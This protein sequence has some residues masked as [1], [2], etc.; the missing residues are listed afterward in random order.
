MILDY[1]DFNKYIEN[2][3]EKKNTS[4]S[5]I[6][7][8]IYET[9]A[10]SDDLLKFSFTILDLA[11]KHRLV[12]PLWRQ[13]HQILLQ[14]D[15]KP[16]IHRFR[17]I[18]ILEVDIQ[19]VMKRWW[20]RE[21]QDSVDSE[22]LMNQKQYARKGVTTMAKLW[23]RH[24]TFSYNMSMGQPFVQ[25]DFDA[26]NF[27]DRVIPK[28][29]HLAAVRMEMQPKNAQL[30]LNMLQSFRHRI[31]IQGSPT[32]GYYSD[33]TMFRILGIGQG[34]GCS[35]ILWGLVNDIT[36]HLMESNS[37]GE[38]FRSPL[39][40]T[41]I[42]SCIEAFVYDVHGGV[43]DD[44]T[45]I[46]NAAKK[47]QLSLTEMILV[48]LHRYERYLRRSGVAWSRASGYFLFPTTNSNGTLFRADTTTLSIIDPYTGK[49]KAIL[50]LSAL[51]PTK[52]P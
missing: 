11:M 29:S 16:F 37:P 42:F 2:I 24:L 47:T 33:S 7:L 4:P 40:P 22:N 28:V 17:Y 21:L 48:Y 3:S 5:C 51:T 45:N 32:Q 14:K 9:L 6:H 44:G 27:Y 23:S 43:N 38:M 25:I 10:Q 46:Y 12:L 52:V 19:F 49:T 20:A 8:G 34:M 36:M 26:K 31:I 30:I 1:E 39:S 18:T 15:N 41:T 50:M 35:Q 13:T